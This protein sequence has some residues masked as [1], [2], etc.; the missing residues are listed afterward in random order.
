VSALLRAAAVIVCGIG[1]WWSCL[2]LRA[3]NLFRAD[4]IAGIREAIRL[5]PDQPAYYVRLAQLDRERSEPLLEKALSLNRYDSRAAIDLGLLREAAGDYAAAEKLFLR[6]FEADRTFLP[7]W[8]LVNYYFRRD[9]IPAFWT[10]ARITAEMPAEDI[11]PLFQLCRRVTPDT[12]AVEQRVITADPAVVRQYLEFLVQGN[13][14]VAAAGLAP[15][16]LRY[17]KPE[18]D[19][20]ALL[21]LVDRLISA[22][23]FAA[24]SEVWSAL[25]GARWIPED[26]FLPYNSAFSRRPMQAGFDWRL[27]A[28]EG[29]NATPGEAGLN[30]EFSGKEPESC[31]IAEQ[32]LPLQPGEH[33]LQYRFRTAG[34]PAGA[35]LHWQIADAMSGAAL[36]T[37]HDLSSEALRQDSFVFRAPDSARFV[38]LRLN[39]QR[40]IGT[41]RISGVLVLASTKLETRVH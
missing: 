2:F 40:A 41:P 27:P 26:R 18:D 6:A 7:R 16:L 20:T 29:L 17:G 4:T 8:T 10:W 36:A 28:H 3:D 32:V 23:D 15:K 25:A 22:G 9:I 11:R 1:I 35:G 34:I 31:A 19:G 13:E 39:Y 12:T 37:S 33:E 30:V 24:A 38:R 21:A 5:V 14:L